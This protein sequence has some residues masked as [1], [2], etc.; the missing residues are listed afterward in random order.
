LATVSLYLDPLSDQW[1]Q[2]VRV[3]CGN[4]R[5]GYCV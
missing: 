3:V 4:W 1:Y 2:M 5:V